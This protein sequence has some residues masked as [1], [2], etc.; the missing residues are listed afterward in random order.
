MTNCIT[1]R[2]LEQFFRGLV[3]NDDRITEIG[4]HLDHCDTCHAVFESIRLDEAHEEIANPF[5]SNASVQ[6]FQRRNSDEHQPT[7]I[8]HFRICHLIARGGTSDVYLAFDEKLQ[9][10]VVIKLFDSM[11]AAREPDLLER[12]TRLLG[13]LSSRKYPP[14]LVEAT[15]VGAYEGVPFIVMK[16]IKGETLTARVPDEGWDIDV[17]CG[18][19]AR[20]AEP[21]AYLHEKKVAHRDIKPSNRV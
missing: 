8:E 12:E 15:H 18:I 3:R 1:R 16:R 11:L 6:T 5:T 19:M 20:V 21:V 14:G 7:R 4:V 13:Q 2:E 10:E 17:V 9:K